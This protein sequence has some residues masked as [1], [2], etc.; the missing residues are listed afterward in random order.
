MPTILFLS[1]APPYRQ[2]G[3]EKVIWDLGK[4]LAKNNWEVHYLCPIQ[5]QRPTE[6]NIT[7]HE[8][9]TPNSFF[10]EKATFFIKGIWKYREVIDRVAPDLIYDNSSPFPFLYA[11]LVDSD[12]L[13]TKVH[14]VY[15]SSA[16]K[17]KNHPITKVGTIAG[18]QLYRLKNG[19]EFVTISPSTKERLSKLVSRNARDISVVPNGIKVNE[20]EYSFSPNGPILSLCELTP[21][22]DIES[23]LRAWK[24]IEV[25]NNV[26][27]ELIIAGDGPRKSD[28]EELA[29]KLKLKQTTFRGFVSEKEKKRLF[30]D[31]YCYVLPTRL[32]GFGLAN[33]EAMASG[34]V[35]ISTDTWG[36]RDYLEHGENGLSVQP[37]SPT[38]IA[39][40]LSEALSDPQSYQEISKNARKTAERYQLKDCV[41][42]ERSVL[43]QML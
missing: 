43:E 31:A 5:G 30:R 22:K 32:E 16:L 12:R 41:E 26:D 24:R 38:Q 28:L 9:K 29:G 8:V 1:K 20:F 25:N 27:Q 4:H 19:E 14:A 10:A 3:A 36:V 7:F 33:L 15:G 34:C 17:N 21:R 40:A 11:H 35:V 18:E 39:R 23:L 6:R 13:V 2:S 42:Y 37:E